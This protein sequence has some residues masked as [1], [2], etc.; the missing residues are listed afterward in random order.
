MKKTIT[1]VFI[2]ILF[3]LNGFAQQSKIIVKGATLTKLSGE[4]AFTEGPAADAEGISNCGC[5][6][7]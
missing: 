5:L 3:V 4:Y 1:S 7:H 2:L 6:N